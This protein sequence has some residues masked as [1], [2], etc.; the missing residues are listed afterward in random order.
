MCTA[1]SVTI[2]GCDCTGD[3]MLTLTSDQTGLPVI[4]RNDGCG[5]GSKCAKFTFADPDN[6]GCQNYEIHQSCAPCTTT[7]TGS[8]S[9]TVFPSVTSY[10][11]YYDDS[12]CKDL[13]DST[14]GPTNGYQCSAVGDSDLYVKVTCE[15]N[16]AESLW[17]AT[18]YANAQCTGNFDE[19]LQSKSACDCMA[20]TAY[21]STE[22]SMRVNCAGTVPSCGASSSDSN[23][24]PSAIAIVIIVGGVV[25]VITVLCLTV[26]CCK[27]WLKCTEKDPI[28]QEAEPLPDPSAPLLPVNAY[29][30]PY[31][32]R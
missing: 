7:C 23:H 9:Y 20:I 12:T 27:G 24:N 5:G 32:I 1:E 17:T 10:V 3:E 4:S 26:A 11:Q 31:Y 8:V 18:V 19:M 29:N 6:A 21:G 13:S 16:T 14:G 15:G 30:D 25:A 28:M 22:Y 2:D